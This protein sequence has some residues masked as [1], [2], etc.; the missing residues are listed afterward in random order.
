MTVPSVVQTPASVIHDTSGRSFMTQRRSSMTATARS[1]MTSPSVV[2]TR[3]SV[4]ATDV[5]VV[6][7]GVVCR[8]GRWPCHQD[9]HAS[10]QLHAPQTFE[11]AAR[12]AM[13][14]P[15]VRD[16]GPVRRDDLTRK[17]GI[18]TACT[19]SRRRRP[20]GGRRARILDSRG[21]PGPCI[22]FD[23]A[24]GDEVAPAARPGPST[25]GAVAR[26]VPELLQK[27]PCAF[28]PHVT[29]GLFT[30]KTAGEG[31]S[32]CS[33]GQPHV[34]GDVAKWTSAEYMNPVANVSD[35]W[36]SP[37]ASEKNDTCLQSTNGICAASGQLKPTPLR[38]RLASA[39]GLHGPVRSALVTADGAQD[40]SSVA[41]CDPA[42]RLLHC[43]PFEHAL[44]RHAKTKR[45]HRGR[46]AHNH[47][48][49]RPQRIPE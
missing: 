21:L 39:G 33:A 17:V 41:G 24:P 7:T 14:G 47:G 36:Q 16:D 20:D 46:S 5:P 22:F 40:R 11:T 42:H 10:R 6:E 3:A 29:S 19:R 4:D 2:I 31:N 48:A 35:T 8:A 38:T 18:A 30:V 26:H 27:S 44:A 37:A 34:G 13:P 43:E 49:L 12:V 23:G 9:R 45:D 15:S 32:P 1:S 28:P 25:V